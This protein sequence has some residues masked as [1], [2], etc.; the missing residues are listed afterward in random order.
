MPDNEAKKALEKKPRKRSPGFPFINLETAVAR[1]QTFFDKNGEHGADPE[2]AVTFWGYSKKSSGGR[3]TIAALKHYG[4]LKVSDDGRVALSDRALDIVMPGSPRRQEAIRQAALAPEEFKALWDE[5]EANLGSL[6]Q[7]AFDLTRNKGFNRN[8][9]ADFIQAYQD[10][11]QYAGL[12]ES[13]EISSG[14]GGKADEGGDG[15]AKDKALKPPEVGAMVQWTA[16]GVDQFAAPRRVRALTPDSAWVFVEGSE[17]GIPTS[18]VTVTGHA[19]E[20]SRVPEP[21]MP[22]PPV[23]P[24]PTE[25]ADTYL[26]TIPFKKKSLSVRV[27][28]PG[29]DLASEH[30]KKVIAHLKLLTDSEEGAE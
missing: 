25:H 6:D 12:G 24:L 17:T 7:L 1:A 26:L 29:E 5:R 15:G 30:F 28:M 14:V 10:T 13:G 21:Q 2:V 27:H 11:I 18:E 16:Q 19:P 20:G 23:L 22:T 8:S 3:Q 9:V 4:L